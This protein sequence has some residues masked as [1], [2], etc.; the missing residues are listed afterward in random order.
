MDWMGPSE[1]KTFIALDGPGWWWPKER[2]IPSHCGPEHDFP[3]RWTVGR[4]W[5]KELAKFLLQYWQIIVV[6]YASGTRMKDCIY[7]RTTTVAIHLQG[8]WHDDPNEVGR[9]PFQREG[10]EGE[11]FCSVQLDSRVP[12][13][14]SIS[15]MRNIQHLSEFY[16]ENPVIPNRMEG[17]VE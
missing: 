11:T 6:Y 16:L 4:G 7:K 17:H 8:G 15:S 13:I 9:K 2:V 5:E 12:W 10:R 1:W 14:S 3:R